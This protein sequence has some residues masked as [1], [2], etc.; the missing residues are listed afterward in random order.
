MKGKVRINILALTAALAV[1]LVAARADALDATNKA[2]VVAY[3]GAE[4]MYI[5]LVGGINYQA[6]KTAPGDCSNYSRSVDTLRAWQ[7]LAQ[8][9]LLAGKSLRIYY[10]SCDP[11]G[12]GAQ[13]PINF[14]VELDLNL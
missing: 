7:S 9:A 5:Q 6:M 4:A 14:I 13:T 2:Q 3:Q 12:T 11:D 8:S 10:D 1:T